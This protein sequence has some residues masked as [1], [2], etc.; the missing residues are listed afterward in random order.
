MT[1]KPATVKIIP[2]STFKADMRA[3]TGPAKNI[4]ISLNPASSKRVEVVLRAILNTAKA[5]SKRESP[6]IKLKTPLAIN[7]LFRL[8]FF[9]LQSVYSPPH[10]L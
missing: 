2:A 5:R 3:A 9:P 6:S 7:Y 1:I 8:G 4:A 10:F